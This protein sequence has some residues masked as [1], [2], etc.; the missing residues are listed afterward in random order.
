MH[1]PSFN[2]FAHG[3]HGQF[4]RQSGNRT[5]SASRLARISLYFFLPCIMRP[6]EKRKLPSGLRRLGRSMKAPCFLAC[7]LS[8]ECPSEPLR[9]CW[10]SQSDCGTQW[11]KLG[12]V[13]ACVTILLSPAGLVYAVGFRSNI[14]A[15]YMIDYVIAS[16][17]PVPHYSQNATTTQRSQHQDVCS[18]LT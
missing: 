11:N 10:K 2:P 8:L 12:A 18:N 9:L 4:R 5:R 14:P 15:S 1:K 16:T 13:P 7:F 17:C 6:Q 3:V